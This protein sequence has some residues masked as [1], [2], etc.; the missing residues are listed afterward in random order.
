M[1]ELGIA[2]ALVEQVEAVRQANG[3]GRV[4][5]VEVLV[6]TWRQVV[7]EILRTYFEHL[8][9]DTPL[10]GATVEVQ[11]VTATARCGR[12]GAE[13]ALEDVYL[14]CPRCGALGCTL[15]TGKELDLVGLELE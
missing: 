15:L 5:A 11:Q 7:P 3:G 10:E 9:R 4:I 2:E 8:T 14:V 6:G 12:C 13:F 1:H